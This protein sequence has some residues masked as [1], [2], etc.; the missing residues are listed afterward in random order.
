MMSQKIVINKQYGGFS[1]SEK[2]VRRLREMGNKAALEEVLLG[3]PWHDTGE[4]ND[5]KFD[6][7]C[8][9]IDRDDPQLIAVIGE[10]GK[11][12]FGY[13]ATLE[14]VEIPDG[15]EWEIAEYDGMESVEEKHRSW[16]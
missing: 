16:G 5:I 4:I 6:A 10:L 12:A 15:V 8:R 7:H 14:I 9:Y 2:A 1:L 11:D 13:L 3:E